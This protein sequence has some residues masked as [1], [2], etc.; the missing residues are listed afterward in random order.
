MDK[1]TVIGFVLIAA[2]LIGF[3]YFSRPSEAEIEAQLR[4]DSI[5]AVARQ[6]AEQTHEFCE[7]LIK[8]MRAQRI[9]F[10]E[11]AAALLRERAQIVTASFDVID[12]AI[13]SSDFNQLSEGLGNIAR[14]FGKELQFKTF[15]EFDEFMK[16]DESFE[17]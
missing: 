2:V 16:S 8:Q 17:L 10:E 5:E 11:N 7:T 3:S 12:K 15:E 14:A 13:L 6:R 4:Q 9:A 1:N